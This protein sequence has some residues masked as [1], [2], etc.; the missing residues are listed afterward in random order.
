MRSRRD[1][2][3]IAPRS[4][5]EIA[6]RRRRDAGPPTQAVTRRS[7]T[8]PPPPS[9]FSRSTRTCAAASSATGARTG[10]RTLSRSS[11]PHQGR[12]ARPQLDGP[13][14]AQVRARRGTRRERSRRRHVHHT[15][16]ARRHAAVPGLLQPQVLR[17]AREDA[18]ARSA[19]DRRARLARGHRESPRDLIARSRRD[20]RRCK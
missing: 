20:L 12:A 13:A 9:S 18:G 3:E 11:R 14:L 5:G 8:P 19:R 4:R 17:A 1:C 15:V 2:A 7:S 16:P 6:K 10:S